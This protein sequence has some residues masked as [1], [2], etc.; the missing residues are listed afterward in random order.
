MASAQK[1]NRSALERPVLSCVHNSACNGKET[2]VKYN[3]YTWAVIS[4][5]VFA[6]PTVAQIV[7][8]TNDPNRPLPEAPIGTK[9]GGSPSS[10][11]A[12]GEAAAAAGAIQNNRDAQAMQSTPPVAT[13]VTTK[14]RASRR[15]RHSTSADTNSGM[16]AG[17]NMGTNSTT[18]TGTSSGSSTRSGY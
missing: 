6:A 1:G 13:T 3:I 15:I 2:Y 9:A 16:R 4:T 12:P 10:M 5:L 7:N 11:Q 18:N 14:H 8:G 17:M